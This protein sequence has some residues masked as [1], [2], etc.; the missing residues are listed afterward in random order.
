MKHVR[1]NADSP[2]TTLC[3]AA[4]TPTYPDKHIVIINCQHGGHSTVTI[5]FPTFPGSSKELEALPIHIKYV[6][7]NQYVY[8]C[9]LGMIAIFLSVSWHTS[10]S[11]ISTK[12]YWNLHLFHVSC[13][14]ENHNNNR[15]SYLTKLVILCDKSKPPE[16]TSFT[17][18]STGQNISINGMLP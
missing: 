4:A 13:K 9:I 15:Y 2:A 7:L 6:I 14:V 1:Q 5:I 12:S 17:G 18:H 11:C 10:V 16:N 8:V 3:F